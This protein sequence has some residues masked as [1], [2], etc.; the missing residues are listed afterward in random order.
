MKMHARLFCKTGQLSGSAFQI[1]Q[2][3]TIGKSAE[4]TIALQPTQIS[5]KHAKIFY[6]NASQ[7]YWIEDLNSRNGTKVDGTSVRG[8]Q[9]LDALNIITFANAYDFIF[10]II[11]KAQDVLTAENEPAH[12]QSVAVGAS[13]TKVSD[14]AFVVP[15]FSQDS[16][17]ERKDRDDSKQKTVLG[18][19]FAPVPHIPEISAQ[20]PKPDADHART[21]I[22]DGAVPPPKIGSEKQ[23]P[24]PRTGIAPTYFLEVDSPQKGKQVFT[25]KE[26]GNVIGRESSCDVFIEDG[27]I[28]REHAVI[29]VT[30]TVATIR[31]LGSKNHTYL[32]NQRVN[33]EMAVKP[34]TVITFGL[35]KATLIRKE[36]REQA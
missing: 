22:D 10:Q 7:S 6:D 11:D 25:L 12:G 23:Q 5:R 31:D 26:G 35:V 36:E 24:A 33:Y 18:E 15:A 21:V 1:D 34:D 9:K 3:A 29:T 14:E 2:D 8:K 17:P 32:E 19:D 13:T 16:A 30:G 27:S 4:N 20:P 28:S